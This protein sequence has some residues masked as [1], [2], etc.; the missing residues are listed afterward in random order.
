MIRAQFQCKEITIDEY[1][2]RIK[3]EVDYKGC[4]DFT[5][6]TPA[7]MMEFRIDKNANAIGKFEV[8]K[9]YNV[10]FTPVE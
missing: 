10:D 5:P 8:G 4:K 2:Q 7:G 1:G 6:Y 9:V 3:M